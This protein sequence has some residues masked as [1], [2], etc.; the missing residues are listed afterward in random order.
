[1]GVEA[2]VLALGWMMGGTVG[3]GT[4]LFVITTGPLLQIFLP[5]FTRPDPAPSSVSPVPSSS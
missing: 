1:M 2:A 5:M 3:V 4:V